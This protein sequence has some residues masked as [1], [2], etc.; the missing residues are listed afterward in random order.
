MRN[1]ETPAPVFFG[2]VYIFGWRTVP[3]IRKMI[4]CFVAIRM[5]HMQP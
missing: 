2:V 1:A 5:K 3:Q 4:V